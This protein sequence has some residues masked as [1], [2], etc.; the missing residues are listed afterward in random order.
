MESG[1][2]LEEGS[3]EELMKNKNSVF[4][5]MNKEQKTKNGN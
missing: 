1:K 4:A 2:V 3:Y 5:R